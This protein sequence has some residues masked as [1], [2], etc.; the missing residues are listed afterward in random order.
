[1]FWPFSRANS[2]TRGL[3]ERGRRSGAAGRPSCAKRLNPREFHRGSTQPI[4]V[5]YLRINQIGAAAELPEILTEA[6]VF[7]SSEKTC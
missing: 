7:L 3:C 2:H 5:L 6:L 1:M 4:K